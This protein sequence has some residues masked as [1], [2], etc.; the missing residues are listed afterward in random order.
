[1]GNAGAV[2][3]DA[4]VSKHPLADGH[5]FLKA[6]DMYDLSEDGSDLSMMDTT[7]HVLER[8]IVVVMIYKC[9]VQRQSS[10]GK[11]HSMFERLRAEIDLVI[12]LLNQKL[13][14][15]LAA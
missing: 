12:L 1:M 7:G 3:P 2:A 15:S 11:F 14:R 9:L 8:M 13:L 4:S 6:F 5:R 10:E